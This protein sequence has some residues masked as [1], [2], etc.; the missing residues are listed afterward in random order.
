MSTKLRGWLRSVQE[1]EGSMIVEASL[2]FPVIFYCTLAILFFAMLIYQTVLSSHAAELAAERAAAF[3]DNSRKEAVTGAFEA[4]Q[5][6]GLYWRLLD[7]RMLDKV[8][9]RGFGGENHMVKLPAA[10]AGG[11]LPERKLIR[12]ARL[13]PDVF[14]G[15]MSYENG[16]LDRRITAALDKPLYQTMFRNIAG[17]EH[18][19]EGQA[20]SAIVEPAEFIRTVEFA[21]YMAAKLKEWKGQGVPTREAEGILKQAAGQISGPS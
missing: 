21:R 8:L 14:H 2:V 20:V 10:A 12:A 13:V 15:K 4:G 1:E 3:W 17:R 6:D 18:S 11:S 5:Q 19:N 7:D 9:G 16:L